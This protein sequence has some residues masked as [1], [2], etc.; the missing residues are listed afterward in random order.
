MAV[1]YL[2][3]LQ[4][5]VTMAVCMSLIQIYKVK[6]I[7]FKGNLHFTLHSLFLQA[8]TLMQTNL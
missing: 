2:V 1:G 4:H 8:L 6:N 5:T 3:T 7:L